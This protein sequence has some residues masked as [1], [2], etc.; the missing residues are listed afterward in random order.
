MTRE[1]FVKELIDWINRRL[2]PPGYVVHP[3]TA[4]FADGMIDSIRI[5][6]LIA[7]VEN[8]TGRQIPDQQIRMDRFRDVETIA[9]TFVEAA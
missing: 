4:L 6:R 7:W 1:S 8:A 5:L 9:D 2:V 3:T